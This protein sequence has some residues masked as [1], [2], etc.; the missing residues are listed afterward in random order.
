MVYSYL[1]KDVYDNKFKDHLDKYKY[2]SKLDISE[3]KF[4][5]EKCKEILS[6]L[7][8][9]SGSRKTSADQFLMGNP[10]PKPP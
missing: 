5:R 2:S 10:N 6:L 1:T 4:H 7:E 8:E 3:P 9:K